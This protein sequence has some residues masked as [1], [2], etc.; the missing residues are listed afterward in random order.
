MINKTEWSFLVLRE[1]V[2]GSSQLG[3]DQIQKSRLKFVLLKPEHPQ[4][5]SMTDYEPSQEQLGLNGLGFQLGYNQI[6]QSND[7]N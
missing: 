3:R 4:L 6:N 1:S 7:M 5:R 2:I